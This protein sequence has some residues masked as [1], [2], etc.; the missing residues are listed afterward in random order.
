[1]IFATK[2]V[3]L[4]EFPFSWESVV[5][6]FLVLLLFSWLFLVVQLCYVVIEMHTS[7]RLNIIINYKIK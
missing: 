7:A 4:T 6:L 5:F 2:L 1:M 3:N